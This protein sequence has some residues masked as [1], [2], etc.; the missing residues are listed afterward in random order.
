MAV[1]VVCRARLRLV[2][3]L[4]G[5]AA[6]LVFGSCGGFCIAKSAELMLGQ[7]GCS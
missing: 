1:L 4:N 3:P 6:V 2:K 5:R 7:T